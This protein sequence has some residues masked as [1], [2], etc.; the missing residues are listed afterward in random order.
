MSEHITKGKEPNLGEVKAPVFQPLWGFGDMFLGSS[1]S[2]QAQR[3]VDVWG[4]RP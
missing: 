1:T 4:P 2:G 3:T